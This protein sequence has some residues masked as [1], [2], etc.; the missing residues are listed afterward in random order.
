MQINTR[1]RRAAK[2]LW[3]CGGRI[4]EVA[5]RQGIQ[6]GTIR[7]WLRDPAF[8][9][10][11]AQNSAEP[12]LQATN[13]VARWAPAAVAR[14]IQD[15]DSESA[16]DARQAAREVLK[17][18]IEAHRALALSARADPTEEADAPPPADPDDPLSRR[19]AALTDDQ[20]VDF[21]AALNGGVAPRL[22]HGPAASQGAS[23]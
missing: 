16:A 3:E 14:L 19:V 22:P 20:L 1:H 9:D 2:L 21:L 8:R 17:L 11:V 12:F 23:L 4:E 10:L 6:P 15:L 18:A 13:A 5:T 7:R